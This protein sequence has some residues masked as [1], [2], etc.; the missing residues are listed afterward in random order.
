M[1]CISL[2]V[3][4]IADF[5]LWFRKAAHLGKYLSM[6][7]SDWIKHIFKAEHGQR[8]SYICAQLLDS[9]L[10]YAVL[11]PH[12]AV[13]LL[14]FLKWVWN[15]SCI[16]ELHRFYCIPENLHQGWGCLGWAHETRDS[17]FIYSLICFCSEPS[18]IYK[19]TVTFSDSLWNPSR[20]PMEETKHETDEKH[21]RGDQMFFNHT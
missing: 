7:L 16:N 18:R 14:T 8:W 10:N 13:H 12:T 11:N 20:L 5:R 19:Y 9:H 4:T 21:P 1:H 17:L 3:N 6:C 2:N 15:Q